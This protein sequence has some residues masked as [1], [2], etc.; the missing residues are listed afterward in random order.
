MSFKSDQFELCY[1]LNV[2]TPKYTT[3]YN[4][5]INMLLQIVFIIY[6]QYLQIVLLQMCVWAD[7]VSKCLTLWVYY[8]NINLN[9]FL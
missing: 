9:F 1:S 4:T 6:W 7:H 5:T 2:C 8:W 3:Y